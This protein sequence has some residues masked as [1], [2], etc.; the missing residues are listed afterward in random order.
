MHMDLHVI[1][2]TDLLS[3]GG[4]E[5]LLEVGGAGRGL[6]HA[7]GA[8]REGFPAFT[9]LLSGGSMEG[10]LEVGVAG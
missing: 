1:G 8:S 6:G 10:L 5:G 9:D 2:F 3:S 4:T 7:H